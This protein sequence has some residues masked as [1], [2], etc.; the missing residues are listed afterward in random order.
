MYNL[1]AGLTVV[2][3]ASF[4]A[5]PCCGLHL[6]QM[7][8]RVIRF[9]QIGGGPDAHRWP[10]AANGAS[11]YWEGLNKGKQS[12]AIDLTRPQGRELAQRIATAGDGLF[13]TNFPADGFLAYDRLA[14][15][16]AD[17]VCLRIMGWADGTPAVDYTINAAVGVPMMTGPADDPRPINH[18][19]PAWDLMAGAYGA[20]ALLGAERERRASGRGR[21]VR[22]ALSDLA[23][24]SL[25]HLGQVADVIAGGDRPRSGNDLFGAFGRDFET[26][27]GQRLMI[28][29][30]T[31]RQWA[32][33]V[34]ALG[35][36]EAVAALEVRT[37]ASFARDEGARFLHR[38]ELTPIVA[39]AVVAR[40]ATELAAAFDEAGV[41]WST[42][43]TLG[44]ALVEEPRLFTENPV[45]APISHPA[46]TYLTPGA[47]ARLPGESAHAP[48]PAPRIG[49]DTDEVLAD[50]L[51]LGSGE[52]ARLHDTGLVA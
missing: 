35:I 4:I 10:R 28:V 41:C 9:D 32:G 14:A 46:G 23:A 43:R 7:G 37:E 52:I 8:A 27:D 25:G 36:G 29:A 33:L 15:L 30:I 6:A 5:G 49:A 17:L 47:A 44:E 22:L 2:E 11:L 18:V 21:E 48:D 1:L 39:A 26:R 51:G 38:A 34:T 3:G 16:R 12:I 42:Y 13:V 50:L 19:L 45:F 31:P 40:D 24:A 20:F